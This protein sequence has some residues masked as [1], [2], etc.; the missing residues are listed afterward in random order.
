MRAYRK[1]IFKESAP[2]WPLIIVIALLFSYTSI[3]YDGNTVQ[4]ERDYILIGHL[5]PSTGPLAMF[6]HISPWTDE[7]VVNW[8]NSQGGIY[9]REYGRKLPVA[10]KVVDT[11]SNITSAVQATVGLITEDKADIIIAAHTPDTVNPASAVCEKYGVPC[12][13]TQAPTEAWL[14]NGP[15]KW[16]Y[17]SCW[18]LDL[19]A[20][21]YIGMVDERA[22]QTNKI[23]ACLWSDATEGEVWGAIFDK[24]LAA[25]GYTAFRYN[26]FS[27]TT[28]DF[29]AAIKFFKSKNADILF[30]LMS[31]ANMLTFWQQCQKIQYIPKMAAIPKAAHLLSMESTPPDGFLGGVWWSP[32][33]PYKSS[34]TGE[35]CLDVCNAWTKET[36]KQWAM[37]IGY[38]YSAFEIAIDALGRAQTLDKE[39]IRQAIEDANFAS[40]AG[41]IKYNPQHYCV[42]PVVGGQ[43]TKNIHGQWEVNIVYS[44]QFH[45]IPKT[46]E[47]IFPLQNIQR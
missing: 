18:T 14:A 23:V 11:Q 45:E 33:H 41:K 21:V 24:K 10:V 13:S 36:G 44:G 7:R 15:Y 4:P 38:I 40:I 25:R 47:M 9:I 26:D 42:L 20:D 29:S 22:E 28:R 35:N 37:G 32:W 43:W 17:H 6:G 34:L 12:I 27:P 1:S 3:A 46:G 31:S 16:S 30:G 5:N 19:L 2:L 39:K 8:I